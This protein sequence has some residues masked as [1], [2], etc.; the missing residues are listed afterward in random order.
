MKTISVSPL[1]LKVGD[2]VIHYS[3]VI[4]VESISAWS[5]G[6]S[7]KIVGCTC[8]IVS[9]TAGSIPKEWIESRATLVARGHNEDLPD[10]RYVS[11]GGGAIA[12]YAKV[13]E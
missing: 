2:K 13:V 9:A 10:G 8:R 3:C 7:K 12:R 4:Q 5:E 11:I 1:D 6:S